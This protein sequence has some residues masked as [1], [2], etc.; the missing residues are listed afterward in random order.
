[1][2]FSIEKGIFGPPDLLLTIGMGRWET[3]FLREKTE[4]TIQ[5][6]YGKRKMGIY[7]S[8]G[9]FDFLKKTESTIQNSFDNRKKEIYVSMGF[10]GVLGVKSWKKGFQTSKINEKWKNSYEKRNFWAQKRDFDHEKGHFWAFLGMKSWK[11]R[12]LAWDSMKKCNFRH[13]K[14]WNPLEKGIFQDWNASSGV[15]WG[16]LFIFFFQKNKIASAILFF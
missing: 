14:Q 13:E 6:P 9:L 2:I 7:V 10:W 4:S 11:K 12:N 5:N 15:F 16:H 3:P 8:M 1:L